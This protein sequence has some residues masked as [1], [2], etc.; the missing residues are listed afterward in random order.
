MTYQHWGLLAGSSLVITILSAC[1]SMSPADDD[2]QAGAKSSISPTQYL[3][4]SH[5]GEEGSVCR[6]TSQ[7]RNPRTFL[8][9]KASDFV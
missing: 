9:E 7:P 8:L 1:T 6:A 2:N 3:E 5:P 4:R